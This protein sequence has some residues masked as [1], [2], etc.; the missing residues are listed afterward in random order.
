MQYD[1]KQFLTKADDPAW[2]T[3]HSSYCFKTVEIYPFLFFA[4][5]FKSLAQRQVVTINSVTQAEGAALY[6][7]LQQTFLGATDVYWL[8]NL[9]SDGREKSRLRRKE[10][11]T[12]L[13]TY[14]GPHQALYFCTDATAQ[15][16]AQTSKATAAIINLPE[17]IDESFVDP[18]LKLLGF[19]FNAQRRALLS[20]AFAAAR[21]VPLDTLCSMFS[22][23]EVINPRSAVDAEHFLVS[24]VEPELSFIE[25]SKHFFNRDAPNF[26]T[27]WESVGPEYPETY[28]ILYWSDQLWRAYHVTAYLQQNKIV[29]AKKMGYRLPFAFTSHL[30]R[31]TNLKELEQGFSFLYKADCAFKNG[32]TFNSLELFFINYFSRKNV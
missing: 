6:A 27:L 13:A 9:D 2:W 25:L 24:L 12:L 5:L 11:L 1:V 15:E 30:W 29:E 28:W 7:L 32:S 21:Q 14:E 10:L 22:Y 26:F 4:Q 18:L 23:L 8:G 20:R 31:K 16:I 3:T 19:Q 17:K